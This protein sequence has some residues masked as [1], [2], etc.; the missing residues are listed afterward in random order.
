MQKALACEEAIEDDK[1][2][3]TL[4]QLAEQK[5]KDG[6]RQEAAAWASEESDRLFAVMLPGLREF[7]HQRQP[8]NI[9]DGLTF[10]L[11]QSWL[12]GEGFSSST[13]GSAM[14]RR[15]RIK[16]DAQLHEWSGVVY[17]ES[18]G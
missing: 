1:A 2:W 13:R 15:L 6:C 5:W 8:G 11:I 7:A 9:S 4:S 12:P 10:K 16:A 18:V 3:C 17:A 14:L